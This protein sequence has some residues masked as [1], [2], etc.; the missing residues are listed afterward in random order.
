MIKGFWLGMLGM[1][2]S[3]S[4]V[5][6]P[7]VV[8]YIYEELGTYWSYGIIIFVLSL[9]LIL[10]LLSYTRLKPKDNDMSRPK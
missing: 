10:I 3:L 8:S 5:V 6:G 7:I 9:A 4:R 1:C 2:G